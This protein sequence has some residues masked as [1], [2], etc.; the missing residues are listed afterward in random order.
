MF[1]LYVLAVGCIIRGGLEI[2]QRVEGKDR[3]LLG[4]I[5]ILERDGLVGGGYL[6]IFVMGGV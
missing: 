1:E 4:C 2:L 3:F 6:D 5:I